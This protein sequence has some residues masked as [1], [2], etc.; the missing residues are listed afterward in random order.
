MRPLQAVDELAV[1]DVPLAAGGTKTGNPEAAEVA[2]FEFSAHAG[3]YSGANVSF[4]GQAVIAAG[5]PAMA[6]Y[7]LENAFF[8]LTVGS[9]LCCSCHVSFPFIV[10]FDC[11]VHW[12]QLNVWPRSKP[13]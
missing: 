4:F 13:F 6:F 8:C 9:A 12:R 5:G 7:A 3:V 2:F 11:K 1:A 10:I